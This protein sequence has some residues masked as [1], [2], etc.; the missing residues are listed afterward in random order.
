MADYIKD[1]R[2]GL[3]RRFRDQGDGSFAE[4][5]IAALGMPTVARG[6]AATTTYATATLTPACTRVSLFARGCD[7][8]YLVGT[9]AQ[10]TITGANGHYIA[11]GERLDLW[12]PANCVITLI[13]ALNASADGQLEI[14]ELQ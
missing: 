9:T 10:P 7:I 2:N 4:V 11:Q 8:R 6:A 1:S 13:R 5:V 3:A 14:S 12:V